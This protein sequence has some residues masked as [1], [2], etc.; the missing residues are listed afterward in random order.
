MCEMW[1][2]TSAFHRNR[3]FA[4]QYSYTCKE[5]RKLETKVYWERA[6]SDAPK[7]EAKA[8]WRDDNRAELNAKARAWYEANKEA[9]K[10]KRRADNA[11]NRQ[12]VSARNK[13]RK[14]LA[15][16]RLTKDKKCARCFASDRPLEGHHH[17]GYDLPLDV[18]WVCRSC[19]R[20]I[21]H[22]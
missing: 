10:A 1:K 17:L 20:Y 16:G 15:S 12:K 7:R 18:V 9:I 5:C 21:E 11:M 14:A 13:V 19:H 8:K 3:R 22:L 6:K 4:R 2:P